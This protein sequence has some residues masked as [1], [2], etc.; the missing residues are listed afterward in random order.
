MGRVQL[1]VMLISKRIHSAIENKC[2]AEPIMCMRVCMIKVRPNWR[3]YLREKYKLTD[4]TGQHNRRTDGRMNGP[5]YEVASHIPIQRL[6]LHKRYELEVNYYQN[7][8]QSERSSVQRNGME[9]IVAEI[10]LV[11]VH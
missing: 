11:G 1:V 9:A 2:A 10:Y 6:L 4:L 3:A 7:D 8:G 5:E